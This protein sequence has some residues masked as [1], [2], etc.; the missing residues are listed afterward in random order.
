MRL[1][2]LF[3]ARRGQHEISAL[4][5]RDEAEMRRG[6]VADR[7]SGLR[8]VQNVLSRLPIQRSDALTHFLKSDPSTLR[9][10][11]RQSFEDSLD[12][13]F[14]AYLAFHF[15]RHGPRGSEIFGDLESGYIANPRLSSGNMGVIAA[16]DVRRNSVFAQ[17]V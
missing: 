17:Y 5:P 15:W 6:K 2:A 11:A 10:I 8:M 9:G 16:I 4:A 12:S 14:C 3:V 13:I 1:A 7:C